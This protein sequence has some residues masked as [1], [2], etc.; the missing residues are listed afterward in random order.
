[1][2]RKKETATKEI[3]TEQTAIKKTRRKEM[4]TSGMSRHVSRRGSLRA[5]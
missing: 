2:V 3:A 1:M 5:L 4:V